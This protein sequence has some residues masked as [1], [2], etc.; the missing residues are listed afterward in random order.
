MNR[1]PVAVLLMALVL[2][3]GV[4]TLGVTGAPLVRSALPTSDAAAVVPQAGGSVCV[5]GADDIDAQASLLML[6]APAVGPDGADVDVEVAEVGGTEARGVLL[7]LGPD[8]QRRVVGPSAPGALE[9]R[10]VELGAEGWLWHG[11]ADLP[12]A[13]WQEWRTAGAP[14]EPRGAVAAE[15]L[16][17]DA[18]VQHVIGL[19]TDGGYE[20]LIRLANPFEADATFA[21]TFVTEDGPTAPIVL[22]NVSVPGGERVTVRVNDHVPEQP[23]IGAIVTVGAGR[24]AVEGLQR[25]IA[26]VGGIEGVAVVPRVTA[27]STTWTFPWLPAGPDVESGVWV[28]NPESRPVVVEFAVHTP[29]GVTVPFQ[30]SIEIGPG[31]LVR[32]DAADLAPDQTRTFGVS[33]RSGTSGVLAAAG[34]VFLADDARRSGLVRFVG[35]AAPD[36]EWSLAG[37]AAPDRETA[38]H[39]VNLA[40]TDAPL[41]VTLTTLH[42]PSTGDEAGDEA[43]DDEQRTVVLEPG[44]L[45]AGAS[46]RIVLPLDGAHAFAAVV[47][48]GPALVVSRTTFGRELLEPVATSASASRSWRVTGPA[49][50]GRRLPGW[51]AGLGA[52]QATAPRMRD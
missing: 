26:A 25:S 37:L 33:L 39:V 27:P 20:A 46:S 9:R 15:C 41:R 6:A 10:D 22:R 2:A 29:Q 11:W 21:L 28:L 8:P 24:L 47:D 36:D 18:P 38:L 35:A 19:R 45:V 16:T 12:V 44:V 4:L 23:D 51:V 1:R 3:L 50:V 49:L 52:T 31:E 17:T 14:G 42:R 40:E 30:D 32:I 5:T 43:G 34:A 7:T 13:A 48:G